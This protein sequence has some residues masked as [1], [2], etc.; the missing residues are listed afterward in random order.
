MSTPDNGER[1]ND[2]LPSSKY[3]SSKIALSSAEG[4]DDMLPLETDAFSPTIACCNGGTSIPLL[5]ESLGSV[6]LPSSGDV[7]N[8]DR[9]SD[10]VQD[11]EYILYNIKKPS[12]GPLKIVRSKDRD[13]YFIQYKD[14]PD[15]KPKTAKKIL[16]K[17]LVASRNE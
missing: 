11:D 12:Y 17:P 8:M 10:D 1:P 13:T 6:R 14:C 9:G 7:D 15:Q 4:D 5:P 2:H 3:E 16:V